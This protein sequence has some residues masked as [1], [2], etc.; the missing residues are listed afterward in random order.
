L[1]TRPLEET[2]ADTLAWERT[3]KPGRR[4]QAGLSDADERSLLAMTTR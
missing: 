3:R 2:L 4:R 1:V